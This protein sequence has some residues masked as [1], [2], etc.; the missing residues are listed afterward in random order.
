MNVDLL[1]RH[2][3][4]GEIDYIARGNQEIERRLWLAKLAG[5]RCELQSVIYKLDTIGIALKAGRI[6]PWET[7]RLLADL[8]EEAGDGQGR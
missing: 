8:F 5:Y 7:E 3:T 6:D 1:D 2:V 4:R